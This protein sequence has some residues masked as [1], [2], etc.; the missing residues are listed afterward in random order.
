MR[1]NALRNKRGALIDKGFIYKVINNRV[2]IGEA[3]HKGTSYPGEHEAIVSRDLWEIIELEQ[4]D[5]S[6]GADRRRLRVRKLRGC[7]Y[8]SGAHDFSIITGGLVVYPASSPK[9]T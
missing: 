4:I 5:N 1:K 6:Y 2:Y 9:A 7:K 8:L 3:V